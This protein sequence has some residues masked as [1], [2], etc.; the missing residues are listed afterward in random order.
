MIASVVSNAPTGVS[1]NKLY[2]NV[3]SALVGKP[4]TEATQLDLGIAIGEIKQSVSLPHLSSPMDL[5]GL[6]AENLEM[7]S[8]A[9]LKEANQLGI[10]Q[11]QIRRYLQAV[12]AKLDNYSAE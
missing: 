2:E 8:N 3:L 12:V 7:L 6:S 11:M 5:G 1:S 4:L 9:I 10:P